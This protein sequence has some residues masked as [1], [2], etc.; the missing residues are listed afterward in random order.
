MLLGIWIGASLLMN[1]IGKAG[2]ETVETVVRSQ[3]AKAQK[4]VKE[5]GAGK[6]RSL[7]RFQVAEQNFQYFQRWE[8]MQLPLGMLLIVMLLFETKANRL[9]LGGLLAM[10]TI[11]AIEYWLI[12][13]QITEIGRAVHFTTQED[14]VPEREAMWN[15]ERAYSMMEVVKLGV[16]GILALRLMYSEKSAKVR[17]RRRKKVDAVDD[18]DDSHVDG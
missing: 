12:T 2:P 5:L 6:T 15:Y 8:L 9:I 3:S 1:W 13:P 10:L 16:G 7:L 14:M 18:A 4:H 17:R 11:V